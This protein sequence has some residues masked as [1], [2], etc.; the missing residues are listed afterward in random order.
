VSAHQIHNPPQ[1]AAADENAPADSAAQ[2]SS[3]DSQVYEVTLWLCALC[4]DGVG[5]ECHVGGCALFLNRAPDLSLRDNPFVTLID[6]APLDYA[7]LKRGTPAQTPEHPRSV[8]LNKIEGVLLDHG[9]PPDS[10]DV[11]VLAWLEQQLA[12][13]DRYRAAE[14][15][16]AAR[17]RENAVTAAHRNNNEG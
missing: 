17:E 5:G 13:L 3:E 9:C 4:L 1:A 10:D 8:A 16:R 12:E 11:Q 14:P 15:E 2:P 6:G 7:T